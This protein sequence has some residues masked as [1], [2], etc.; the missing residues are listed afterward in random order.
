M[1][2]GHTRRVVAVVAGRTGIVNSLVIKH[3]RCESAAS[4]MA[5]ATV[6]GGGYMWRIGFGG[7]PG[8]IGAIVAAV[9]AITGHGRPGM[10]NKCIGETAGV[11]TGL[12]IFIGVSMDSGWR[13]PRRTCGDVV[14]NTVMAGDTVSSNALVIKYRRDK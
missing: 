5:E 9:A 8:G 11:M 4:G 1:V 14:G 10:I 2:I 13:R 6:I 3:G 7:H 12:A